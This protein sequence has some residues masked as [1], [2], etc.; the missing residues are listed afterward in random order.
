MWGTFQYAMR[1]FPSKVP[2]E[3]EKNII[4]CLQMTGKFKHTPYSTTDHAFLRAYV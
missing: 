1:K 2:R 4:Y 3:M